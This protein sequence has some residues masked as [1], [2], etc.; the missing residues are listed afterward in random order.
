MRPIR[1]F[2]LRQGRLT[3]GQE[4]ALEKVW[5]I[6]GVEESDSI[7]DPKSLFKNDFP[8]TLEIGFGNGESLASMAKS[9]PDTNFIGVE[10]HKPGIGHL[11]HLIDELE[12]KNVRVMNGDA[13]EIL[14]NR[15]PDSSLD[16]VQL[17]FPD[18]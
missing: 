18:P 15:I 3:K 2:V 13:V 5:P 10:V 17:F 1:S 9:S 4:Q 12:L 8:V 7:L 16:C 6:Y 14:E 11:L